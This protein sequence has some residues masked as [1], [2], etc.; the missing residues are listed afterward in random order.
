MQQLEHV[1]IEH[2][3]QFLSHNH[4]LLLCLLLLCCGVEINHCCYNCF[5]LPH[6]R[7]SVCK[8]VQSVGKMEAMQCLVIINKG[9]EPLNDILIPYSQVNKI[10]QYLKSFHK[11]VRG[12][13]ESLSSDDWRI[14]LE[15][16]IADYIKGVH[17]IISSKPA[18]D[19]KAP[20][21]FQKAAR[22]F[23]CNQCIEEDCK[24]PVACQSNLFEDINVIELRRTYIECNLSFTLPNY[25]NVIWKFARN[26]RVTDLSYF[27]DIHRGEDLYVLIQPTRAYHQGTYACEIIDDNDDIIAQK[28][29]F[30]NVSRNRFNADHQLEEIF[31]MVLQSNTSAE[32]EEVEQTYL[33][34]EELVTSQKL[35]GITT[36]VFI[37]AGIALIFMLLTL[38]AGVLFRYATDVE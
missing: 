4:C 21:G 29:Y 5:T 26:I 32:P 36:C 38:L 8:H 17:D 16:K 3:F 1:T 11:A 19:C 34:F 12:I 2:I 6:E 27:K 30:V 7:A 15:K 18:E 28:F 35:M 10:K 25:I 22:K 24:F 23:K 31:Q 9:F 14:A 13:Q 37:T 20:C 33:S